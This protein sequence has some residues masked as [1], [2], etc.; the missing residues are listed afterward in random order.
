MCGIIGSFNKD[1]LIE[2]SL[3][4]SARGNKAYSLTVIDSNTSLVYKE[5]KSKGLF[6]SEVFDKLGDIELLNVYYILHIQSPTAVTNLTEDTI[7]P[8]VNNNHKIWHNGMLL[9]K[10]IDELNLKNNSNEQWDTKIILDE[11]VNNGFDC[12]NGM[13]GSFG[14]IYSNGNK[15]YMFRNNIIPLFIDNDLNISSA[16]FENSNLIESNIIYEINFTD[17]QIIKFKQI[18]NEHNPYVLKG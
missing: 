17:K 10:T 3:K 1:K 18:T 14:I 11:L 9:P 4:N 15:F 12:L 6:S 8:A 7:H 13:E 16:K 5:I 2:L